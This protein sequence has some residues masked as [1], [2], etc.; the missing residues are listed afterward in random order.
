MSAVHAT[1]L[2]WSLSLAGPADPRWTGAMPVDA[3]LQ[4][5][6]D[7]GRRMHACLHR[8]FDDGAER[9]LIVGSDISGLASSHV[10]TA[11]AALD[12]HEVVLG[13]SGDGGY[14]LMGQRAPGVDCFTGVPWSSPDTLAA[15]RQRLEELGAAWHELEVLTDIDTLDDLEHTLDDPRVDAE[16]RHRL[17]AMMP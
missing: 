1:G 5:E 6:G 17:R 13:P 7:L 3:E 12:G 8:W 11:L 10:L 14:W 2:P 15:T 16:L 4:V 9:V